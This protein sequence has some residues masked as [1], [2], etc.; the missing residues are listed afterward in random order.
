MEDI[1]IGDPQYSEDFQKSLGGS[2]GF[3]RLRNIIPDKCS[4]VRIG[5][6]VLFPAKLSYTSKFTRMWSHTYR[7][8]TVLY[9][10]N[11][12]S[13]CWVNCHINV[14][15][16]CV[17]KKW[18]WNRDCKK[19]SSYVRSLSVM[20]ANFW[21]SANSSS[22]NKISNIFLPNIENMLFGRYFWK[23]YLIKSEYDRIWKK[24]VEPILLKG[25]HRDLL[26][27]CELFWDGITK[28]EI[29]KKN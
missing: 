25:I 13:G 21:K 14:Y 9:R 24:I 4:E 7:K 22:H 26:P 15:I 2:Y 11:S 3:Q 8:L 16:I 10:Q 1:Q 19:I 20:F 23:F 28:M 27:N 6:E 18:N 17:V 5:G 12:V 29:L